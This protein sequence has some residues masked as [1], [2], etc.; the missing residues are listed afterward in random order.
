MNDEMTFWE[1]YALAEI[2]EHR[3]RGWMYLWRQQTMKKLNARGYVV[4]SLGGT[5][6]TPAW[7]ITEAGRAALEKMR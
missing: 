4:R 5:R 2:A 6:I 1:K 3:A 7:D